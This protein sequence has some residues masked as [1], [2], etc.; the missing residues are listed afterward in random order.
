MRR[1]GWNSTHSPWW[2]CFPSCVFFNLYWRCNNSPVTHKQNIKKMHSFFCL[3]NNHLSSMTILEMTNEAEWFARS[4]WKAWWKSW[5]H[6]KPHNSSMLNELL[7]SGEDT[8]NVCMWTCLQGSVLQGK[9][10]PFFQ[11]R[12]I[13]TS[14]LKCFLEI[15]LSSLLWLQWCKLSTYFLVFGL[16]EVDP[17]LVSQPPVSPAYNPPFPIIGTSVFLEHNVLT[18]SWSL[19]LPSSKLRS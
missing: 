10:T 8:K 11:T 16:F 17:Y 1:G 5:Q 19:H 9:F 12:I 13:F 6:F 14:S 18:V 2:Y 4:V 15:I 7:K 3:I